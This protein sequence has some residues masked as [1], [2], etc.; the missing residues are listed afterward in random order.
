MK[1]LKLTKKLNISNTYIDFSN[2]V[3]SG[4]KAQNKLFSGCK[5]SETYL[6]GAIFEGC[7]FY[8]CE[9]S[10]S[11]FQ[12]CQFIDCTFKFCH[13]NENELQDIEF[14]NCTWV[15]GSFRENLIIE[16]TIDDYLVDQQYQNDNT[17]TDCKM[18]IFLEMAA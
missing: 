12:N 13:F 18:S 1:L 17:F 11:I 14:T 5:M 4:M 15:L 10:N 7:E 2:L 9:I 16:S 6:E 8:A 3:D